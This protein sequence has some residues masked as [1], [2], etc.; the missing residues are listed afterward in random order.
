MIILSFCIVR[1]QECI[2][3]WV[4][5]LGCL[6]FAYIYGVEVISIILGLGDLILIFGGY[7]NL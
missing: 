4:I 3:I 2:D 7:G 6:Y 5:P 1:L